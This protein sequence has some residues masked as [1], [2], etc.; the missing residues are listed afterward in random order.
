MVIIIDFQN[1]DVVIK[2]NLISK[3]I[4]NILRALWWRYTKNYRRCTTTNA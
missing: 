4:D 2:S 1:I 3:L